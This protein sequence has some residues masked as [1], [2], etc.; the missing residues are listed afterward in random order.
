MFG[1]SWRDFWVD[2]YQMIEDKEVDLMKTF[3][4]C[5]GVM[6]LMRL[7][8]TLEKLDDIIRDCNDP[9]EKAELFQEKLVLQRQRESLSTIRT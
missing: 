8:E 7:D 5:R 2:S 4:E 3:E 1:T 9:S 6:R